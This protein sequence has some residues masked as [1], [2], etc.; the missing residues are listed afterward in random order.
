MVRA[1]HWL[2]ALQDGAYDSIEDLAAAQNIHPKVVRQ[3]LRLAFL[4]PS[5]V[6]AILNG[7][8]PT[9]IKREPPWK[10]LPLAWT[11]QQLLLG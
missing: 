7:T 1:I 8:Q 3:E 10:T 11:D 5:V 4:S 6:S 2:L 9:D